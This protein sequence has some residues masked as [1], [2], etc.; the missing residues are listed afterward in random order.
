[1]INGIIK[2]SKERMDKSTTSL[3]N[4]LAKIRAGRAHPSLLDQVLVE[5]YGSLVPISQVASIT[6]ENARTL[7]ITPWEKDM[8][9]AIEKAIMTADLGLNP[10]SAGVVIRIPLPP[11]TA[12]RRKDLIRIVKEEGEKARVAIRNIRRDTNGD[13]KDLL[14]EKEI[15]QDEFRNSEEKVQ[16]LTNNYINQIDGILADKESSLLDI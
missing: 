3:Q 2:D 14:K 10:N 13:F 12:E 8:V 6:A 7:K 15:S 9:S 11:L 5:Y 1:M 4:S 16:Q